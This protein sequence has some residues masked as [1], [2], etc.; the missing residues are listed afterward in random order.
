[1]NS[2]KIII[3]FILFTIFLSGTITMTVYATPNTAP[4]NIAPLMLF[5][6]NNPIND[7]YNV[8]GI[9]AGNIMGGCKE[10][11]DGYSWGSRIY[12]LI[13]APGWNTDSDK[14]DVIGNNKHNPITANSREGN[15][16]LEGNGCNGF[17]E[18]APDHGLFYGSIKLSGFK[19]DINGDGR[20]DLYGGNRC[21]RNN[22]VIDDGAGR[23]E[24]KQEGGVTVNFEWREDEI[25]SKTALYSWRDA[26]L[27][28]DKT[29]YDVSDEIQLTLT[30]LDN[31]R[32]PFDKKQ[33]YEIHVYS[34]SDSAGILM[35]AYWVPNYKG[36][37]QMNG[38]YPIKLNLT[39][40]DESYESSAPFGFSS[41]LL[42]V[43]PGDTIYAKYWDYSLPKPYSTEDQKEIV[44]T[45]KV[46]DLAFDTTIPLEVS[47]EITDSNG[48]TLH[49]C[50]KGEN[51]KIKTNVSNTKDEPVSAYI[52]TQIKDS[53]NVTQHVSWSA[54]NIAPGKTS[55][56]N[57]EW[58]MKNDG[59]HTFE[60]F[61]WSSLWNQNPMSEPLILVI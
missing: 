60:I 58:I 42:R 53:N 38:H 27:E 59:V 6:A 34:D 3:Y 36:I 29:E 45:T 41:G 32:W 50:I 31:M 61:I 56:I 52:I 17:I 12:I 26:T 57:S 18:T 2:N 9:T 7:K 14:L 20:P 54:I 4:Q 10:K 11:L 25:V 16:S 39:F 55:D 21:E 8:D 30:D 28:F 23:V 44:A 37:V 40:D 13:Y 35:D 5:C 48:K 33:P 51:V 47:T 24:A 22:S 15:M 19:H 1:L 49:H 43:S 46:N